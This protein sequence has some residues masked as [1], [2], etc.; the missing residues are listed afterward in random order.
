MVAVLIMEEDF[1]V[2]E[3]YIHD[4]PE[5][6]WEQDYILLYYKSFML[7]LHLWLLSYLGIYVLRGLEGTVGSNI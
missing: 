7:Q 4:S 3:F 5:I 2:S 6:C 1:I